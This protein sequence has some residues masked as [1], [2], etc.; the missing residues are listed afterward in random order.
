MVAPTLDELTQSMIGRWHGTGDGF[1]QSWNLELVFN[2]DGTYTTS[3]DGN[4]VA[5][6]YGN[7]GADPRKQWFLTDIHTNGDGKGT[8]DVVFPFDNDAREGTLDRIRVCA[9]GQRLDFVLFPSW[10]GM[11]GPVKYHLAKLQL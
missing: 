4:C 1:G 7:D 6:Y 2:T 8:I 5:L 3:C 11:L 9:N 10:L